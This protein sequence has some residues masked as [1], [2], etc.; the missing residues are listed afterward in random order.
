MASLQGL[1]THARM[2]GQIHLDWLRLLWVLVDTQKQFY[3]ERMGQEDEIGTKSS[4]RARTK[5][6]NFDKTFIGRVIALGCTTRCHQSL[7]I[8]A[9]PR[10]GFVNSL[11]W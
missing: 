2:S 8:L 6:I 11:P 3:H 7:H 4:R 10:P 5:N 1:R 9:L